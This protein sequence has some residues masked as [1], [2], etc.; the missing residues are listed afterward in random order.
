VNVPFFNVPADGDPRRKLLL[1]LFGAALAAVDG[2]RRVRAALTGREAPGPVSA[3]AVG[4]AAA[5]MMLGATD[6][7]GARLERGLVVAPDGA[8]PPALRKQSGMLALEAGHPR[9]D[10]RSLAAG[11]AL[12]AFAAATPPGSRVLLLVS[13]GASALLEVPAPGVGLAELGAL[14]ERSLRE[15][16]DIERLN[17]ERI[18]LSRVKGGRLA[19]LFKGAVIEALMISDVPRDDPAVLASGLLDTPGLERRLVGSIV[20]ALAAVERAAAQRG[21]KVARGVERLAGDAEAAAR[22]ICHDLAVGEMDL[23][24]H[25]GETVV[26]LPERPGRGGRCQHLAVAAARHLAGHADYL[27][28]AAGTDGQDGASDDAGAIV[29]GGTIARAAGV[30]MDA[31]AALSAADTGPFLEATGDLVHTGLTGTNVGDIVL[32]LRQAPP[33]TGRM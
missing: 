24:I 18:A 23:H 1:E 15:G 31:A 28:L 26:N 12:L 14:F 25:G 11:A 16:L 30:D 9:P 3:F 7:L 32:A 2:R 5:S 29:D 21:L 19:G 33:N 6:A 13:G 22:R 8:V 4:K 20:E 10:E 17:R 27:L